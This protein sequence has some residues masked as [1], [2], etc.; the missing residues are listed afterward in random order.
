MITF[1]LTEVHR[2]TSD[3]GVRMDRC[4]SGEGMECATL[5]EAF[6]HYARLCGEFIEGVRRWGDA[7]FSGRAGFD[8]E[9]ERVL[10]EE[11]HQLHGRAVELLGRGPRVGGTSSPP[12][13]QQALRSAL[14]DLDRLLRG[15]V[16]PR[17]SSGPSARRRLRPGQA[18]TEEELRQVAAHPHLPADWEPDDP[19]QR[20]LW[21]KLRDA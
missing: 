12:G 19:R 7:V 10:R 11:G 6:G 18:A 21:R 17:P 20:A 14:W 16:T 15:W 1:D 13:G 9:V 2:F 5:D 3:L 8:P 4:L